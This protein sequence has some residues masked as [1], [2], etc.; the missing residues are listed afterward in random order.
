MISLKSIFY[1]VIVLMFLSWIAMSCKKNETPKESQSSDPI[2]TEVGEPTGDA[3]TASIGPAGGTISSSDGNITVNIPANALSAT[4]AITI[5][6]I[7]NNAPLG[8]GTGYRLM[9]EGTTFAAPV[10]LT[11][12]Y[13]QEAL[14]NTPEDFLWIVTQAS[15]GIWN[16]MLKSVLDTIHKTVTVQSTHFSDWMLG[17]FIDLTLTP[18]VTTVKK[19]GSVKLKIS[20]FV[21]NNANE[22]LQPLTYFNGSGV[23]ASPV[24]SRLVDFKV[25]QWTMNG[26]V[27]PVSNDNGSLNPSDNDATYTAPGILPKANPV[28]VSVQLQTSDKYGIKKKFMLVS[29]ITVADDYY[30]K[31][32]IDGQTY[33]YNK[34][35]SL[36]PELRC[37]YNSKEFS[38]FCDQLDPSD[39]TGV[40]RQN[41]F[42]I[43][44]LNPALGFKS[45]DKQ[46]LFRLIEHT[47][48]SVGAY[49]LAST[50][51]KQ[52]ANGC[53][54][55]D[56]FGVLNFTLLSADKIDQDYYLVS[57]KFSGTIYNDPDMC[58]EATAHNVTGEFILKGFAN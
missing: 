47:F 55:S 34:T 25:T 32:V 11:F 1:S 45:L 39:K 50:T 46:D 38:I 36:T 13:T 17:K 37:T 8:V 27:A 57:G 6:P 20:G 29:N 19:G 48:T 2:K 51:Y 23:P 44:V 5:Q 26:V 28:A 58:N 15:N 3:T 49:S 35:D 43:N 53:D 41:Y 7:T 4:T 42:N 31:V 18:A 54:I 21:G 14:E 40:L 9:P 22:E 30:V 16:A 10:T 24:Q 33:Y 56:I 52:T 12:N